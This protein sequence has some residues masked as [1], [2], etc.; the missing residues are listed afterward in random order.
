V[1]KDHGFIHLCARQCNT[2]SSRILS[3]KSHGL[4]HDTETAAMI[5]KKSP[6]F[7]HLSCRSWHFTTTSATQGR[8]E[9][10]QKVRQCIGV[11][12]GF[13]AKGPL[14]QMGEEI[15]YW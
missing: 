15:Y 3:P 1:A 7:P 10:T 11:G 8:R 4:H 6:S 2:V 14:D 12:S 9:N 5:L 13:V